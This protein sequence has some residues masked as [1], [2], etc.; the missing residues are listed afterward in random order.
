MQASFLTRRRRGSHSRVHRRCNLPARHHGFLGA[1]LI[2]QERLARLDGGRANAAQKR[3]VDMNL[4][5]LRR[6]PRL[7]GGR[8]LLGDEAL[9]LAGHLV[10]SHLLGILPDAAHLVIHRVHQ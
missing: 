8:G 1:L 3:T 4:G 2:Y 10:G 6:K 5:G 7:M 9:K